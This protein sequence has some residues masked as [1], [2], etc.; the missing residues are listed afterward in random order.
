M[1][2]GRL[3]MLAGTAID[4]SVPPFDLMPYSNVPCS[5]ELGPGVLRSSILSPWGL[6]FCMNHG[7]GL[8]ISTRRKIGLEVANVTQHDISGQ[9]EFFMMRK[10]V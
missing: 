8:E 10:S 2:K 9:R 1:E 3:K 5:G 4:T 7:P 6:L